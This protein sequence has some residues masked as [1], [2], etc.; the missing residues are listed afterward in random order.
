M[1]ME[2]LLQ[3][4]GLAVLL[5]LS[6]F[7]SGSET[8]LFSLSRAQVQRLRQSGGRTG[9]AAADLLAFPRRLLITILVGNMVVNVATASILATLATRLVGNSGIGLAIFVATL[10]LLIFGE[11]TPKTFAVRNA[12]VVSRLAALPLSAF[13]R[14]I[15]PVR[16]VL[17]HITNA[18][19]FLLQHGRIQS[20]RL[21]TSRELAAAFELGEAEGVIDTLER[22]MIEH[23]FEFRHIDARELMVPRTEL[24]CVPESATIAEA[25]ALSRA[26]GRSRLPVH[27][28]QVDEI[29]GVLDIR[30][31][32]A[33]RGHDIHDR[34]IRDFV[35]FRDGLGETPPRPLVRP[36]FLVPETRH[37]GDLLQ[38]MRR[39]GSHMALLV[40]EYGGTAGIV[41]LR[42]IV[43]EFLGGVPAR[44]RNGAPL[45]VKRRRGLEILGEARVRDVNQELGLDLPLGIAD[46]VGGYVLSLFGDLPTENEQVADERYVFR[47]LRL[48]G[49]RIDAVAVQT[50]TPPPADRPE[51]PVWQRRANGDSGRTGTP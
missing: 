13:A 45:Y 21:L 50:P 16:C 25:V 36:A 11:V 31:L 33:W 24:V 46:T 14:A 20:E 23:I 5:G 9:R 47:V 29:W 10:L 8:A 12:V 2:I 30:E 17:R 27:S 48:D 28:G 22:E 51:G 18:L 42:R 43:D 39:T 37:A 1:L 41:T 40:D 26:S 15:F 44:G 34:T 6:A 3:L 7:F 19:L 49:R 38:D 35:A 32:A 4:G